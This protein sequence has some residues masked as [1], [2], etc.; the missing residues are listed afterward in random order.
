MVS[1]CLCPGQMGKKRRVVHDEPVHDEAQRGDDEEGIRRGKDVLAREEAGNERSGAGE[2][3][4]S[5]AA[6]M[7]IEDT[8]AAS[9]LCFC[10][11]LFRLFF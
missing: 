6:A 8:K 2:D 3:T 9:S 11:T 4:N 10:K 5:L 7:I 1:R